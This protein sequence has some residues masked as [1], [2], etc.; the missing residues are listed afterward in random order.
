M[1]QYQTFVKPMHEQF[2]EP[3]KSRADVIV[4]S[5]TGKSVDIAI[6]ML[7]NHLRVVGGLVESQKEEET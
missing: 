5:E 2:V 1:E 3:S 4:N 6:Q 7:A